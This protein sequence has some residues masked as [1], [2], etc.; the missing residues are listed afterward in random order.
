[1]AALLWFSGTL[2]RGVTERGYSHFLAIHCVSTRS[3]RQPYCHTNATSF[4]CWR[5]TK[6]RATIACQYTVCTSRRGDIALRSRLPRKCHYPLFAYPLFKRALLW[7][8]DSERAYKKMMR[9]CADRHLQRHWDRVWPS[10]ICPWAQAEGRRRPSEGELEAWKSAM[11]VK[12]GRQE[13]IRI[14]KLARSNFKL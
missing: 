11:F 6:L 14:G 5:T 2:K 4:L 10:S 7:F 8:G 3:D 1:M 12:G 9:C 13:R